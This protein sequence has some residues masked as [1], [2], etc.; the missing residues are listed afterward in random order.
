MTARDPEALLGYWFNPATEK[1]WFAPPDAAFDAEI[2][3]R[4]AELYADAR[5]GGLDY[6]RET[7]RGTL[8]LVVALD[9]F[10][11]H[12]FRGTARAFE[13]DEEAR[14]VADHA[15]ALQQDRPLAPVERRFLYLPFMHSENLDDQ[16]RACALFAALDDPEGLKAAEEHRA[17]IERFGRFPHR[18]AAL[19]RASTP[20]EQ[21]F[22]D[23][24]AWP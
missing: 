24:G 22:L 19:G 8:A 4:F 14:A 18:N 11:R 21:A 3:D 1:R 6:W 15:V 5:A 7:P 20:E 17:V 9:Q 12:M 10:P 2:A 16:H 13:A 23:Q